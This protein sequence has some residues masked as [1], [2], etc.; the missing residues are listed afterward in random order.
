MSGLREQTYSRRA[1]AAF[2]RDIARM[3]VGLV[4]FKPDDSGASAVEFA[5]ISPLLL[6]IAIGSLV[7]AIV[8]NNYVLVTNA[9]AAGVG[10]LIVSRGSSTPY[11]DT[12]AAVQQAAPSLAR[13]DLAVTLSVDGVACA[14]DSSC[15]AALG[16]A[17]GKTAGV[18]VSYPC[19]LVVLNIDYAPGGCTLRQ[20]TMG[21]IQ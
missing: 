9:S 16:A 17:S 20:T 7:F 12:I 21:R 14:D 1:A 8:L 11:S 13:A 4:Q 18:A 6:S 5:L 2:A 15:E 3:R 10:N 19:R